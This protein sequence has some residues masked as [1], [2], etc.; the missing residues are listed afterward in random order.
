[1]AAFLAGGLAPA[2]AQDAPSAAQN[3]SPASAL[4]LELNTAND[5]GDG[6]RLAFV[7]YNGTDRALEAVS[8]EVV[9]FD[10]GQ[11]ISQFVLLDFGALPQRKTKIVQFDIANSK[12]ADISR[13]VINSAS[14]C[15]AGGATLPLCLDAA[16]PTSRT[17]IALDL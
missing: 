14:R 6:C 8:Y 2:A 3:A 4:A 15:E 17:S 1:M 5:V 12:C 7:A 11:R 13:I 9:V 10:G 16:K